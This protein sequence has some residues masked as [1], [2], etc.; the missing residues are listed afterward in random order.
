MGLFNTK[1]EEGGGYLFRD[2][3]AY[4]TFLLGNF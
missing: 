2:L 3:V 1:E 4:H